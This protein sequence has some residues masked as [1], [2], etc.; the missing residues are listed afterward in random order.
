M[1]WSSSKS[2]E[3]YINYQDERL[4]RATMKKVNNEDNYEEDDIIST[5][6]KINEE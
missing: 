3:P 6:R 5:I 4:L 1:G 2:L